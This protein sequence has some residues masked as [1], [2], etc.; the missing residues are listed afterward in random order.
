[1]THLEDL[2]TA[3]ALISKVFHENWEHAGKDYLWMSNI[4]I[5]MGNLDNVITQFVEDKWRVKGD[6]VGE[7][8]NANNSEKSS[9]EMLKNKN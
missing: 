9:L 6:Y 4:L 3:R 5:T 8:V 7:R 2:Q 1:M